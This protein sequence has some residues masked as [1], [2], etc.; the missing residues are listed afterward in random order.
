MTASATYLDSFSINIIFIAL[1]ACALAS[2]IAYRVGL[3]TGA[4][5]QHRRDQVT[6]NLQARHLREANN[7]IERMKTQATALHASQNLHLDR[8]ASL[9]KQADNLATKQQHHQ[10]QLEA[11]MQ[12]ADTRIAIYARRANPFTHDD[13]ITLQ[14]A[15]NQLD[16]AANVY[17]G[18]QAGDQVRFARQMQQRLLNLAERLLATLKA[19]EQPTTEEPCVIQRSYLVHGPEA[20]GKP[21]NARA[22]ADALDLTHIVDYWGARAPFPPLDTLVLTNQPGDYSK[23]RD[24]VLTYEQAMQRV[25]LANKKAAE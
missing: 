24:H 18:L 22:I 16:A 11:I 15:A 14:A 19:S 5:A 13:R 10:A 2:L 25:A 7:A 17:A 1:L 12:D 8:A 20:C 23:F 3:G 6:S 9:Q 4:Q 21:T